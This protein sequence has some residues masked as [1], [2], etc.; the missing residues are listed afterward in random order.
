MDAHAARG[1]DERTLTGRMR[2]KL[3]H[4]TFRTSP[5]QRFRPHTAP[6]KIDVPRRFCLT[7]PICGAAS[8]PLRNRR[9]SLGTRVSRQP[10][11]RFR[12]SACRHPQEGE[13]IIRSTESAAK[14]AM[15]SRL[16]PC[17]I[18]PR[19]VSWKVPGIVVVM[20]RTAV[21]LKCSVSLADLRSALNGTS[22]ILIGTDLRGL[23][24]HRGNFAREIAEDIPLPLLQ[25]EE[26]GD[27]ETPGIK[28]GVAF[29]SSFQKAPDRSDAFLS[30]AELNVVH[31]GTCPS[32]SSL[33]LRCVE[34][35]P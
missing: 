7:L 8:R 11:P 30:T 9:P 2:R 33:S 10:R 5:R 15:T 35:A 22:T 16:S 25:L 18:S 12:V 14:P 26:I 19:R 3:T 34:L 20:G 13:I 27:D 21:I 23:R 6:D 4:Q 31:S 1:R 28:R 24:L 29:P 17:T 32:L